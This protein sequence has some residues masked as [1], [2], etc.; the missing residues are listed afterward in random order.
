MIRK[1][2]TKIFLL[3]FLII[4]IFMVGFA[5]LRYSEGN[6]T[7]LMFQDREQDRRL[8]FDR[9]VKIK[10]ESLETLAFDYTYLDEMVNFI[11]AGD[12]VW[13]SEMLDTSL[14]GYKV[15]AMW[16]YRTD[17]S[18]VYS[19]RKGKDKNIKDEEIP[20]PK[21]ALGKLLG[22]KRFCHFFLN[23]S[24]G[25]MEVYGA[26]IHPTKDYERKTPPR[27]YFFVGRL[28]NKDYIN[29]LSRLT[30]STIKILPIE[31][32]VPE[33][34]YDQKRGVINFSKT[35]PSWDEK[36]LMRINVL[37][38]S[39]IFKQLYRSSN[40]Q[41]ALFAIFALVLLVLIF[42]SLLGWVSF[43]LQLISR[44][45]NSEDPTIIISLQK[46]KTE[47]GALAQ[48]IY[49]FFEQKADL[50]R[51]ITGRK[52]VEEELRRAQDE[53]E[54]RVEERT[55][56]LAKAN[57]AL[58]EARDELEAKVAERTKELVQANIQLKEIDR[59]KSEFL[60]NMSH[61]LRTPLNSIIGFSEML[62][63]KPFGELNEKQ[64]RYINNILT[65]GR[66]LLQL[67]N[68]ILDLSKV[69]AGQ[70]MLQFEEFSLTEALSEVETIINPTVEKKG[71][72]LE[73]S[74]D[75]GV[76]TIWA[77]EG[78]LK[79]VMYN[80]LSNA[81]K[82]TESGGVSVKARSVQG[83]EDVIEVSVKDTGIG[84]KAEDMGKLFREFEQIDSGISRMY[85]GTGLGLSLS[86]KLVELHGGEIWVESEYGKGSKF[87]FTLPLRPIGLNT[88]E[89]YGGGDKS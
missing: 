68:N 74:I 80:L 37:S 62:L 41:F 53:L 72:K 19:A 2:Q 3:L 16:I 71:L 46:D 89:A 85:E 52:R 18:L 40:W 77:D 31:A 48:L 51:E 33:S 83:V 55:V 39:P 59:H 60:A 15:D 21:G 49:K 23:A 88:E 86:K 28:W 13:A 1:V 32:E 47:F 9:L 82:F 76:K 35:L 8:F 26:T 69:E 73:F 12:R 11:K 22:Q 20:L 64:E 6:R 38:E 57:Q 4:A 65:S 36:P 75:D 17:G 81:I 29:E 56:E 10:G 61:E 44:S 66:H 7:H 43:P 24:Q 25:L 50:V 45:L 30:E 27:G 79:Q 70:M 58:R 5:L 54:I 78:K 42:V 14:S 63:D 67:I 34:S 84:I 87:T